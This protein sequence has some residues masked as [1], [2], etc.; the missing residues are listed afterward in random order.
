MDTENKQYQKGLTRE[1]LTIGV[2]SFME[3][4]FTTF[5]SVIDSKMVSAM[6]TSAIS[7][8]SVTNQPRLFIFSLFFALNTVITSLVAKYNGANDQES[9][10]RVFDHVIKHF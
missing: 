9:A 6:G 2:P 5:A 1:I 4:L 3:T 10:N 8:V 7:A